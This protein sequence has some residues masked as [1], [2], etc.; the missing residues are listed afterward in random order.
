VQLVKA[1]VAADAA[2]LTT[3]DDSADVC[4]TE[5]AAERTGQQA[6]TATRGREFHWIGRQGRAAA[7]TQQWCLKFSLR[8]RS[9]RRSRAGRGAVED[10]WAVAP[11]ATEHGRE[12][13]RRTTT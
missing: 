1:A 10:D 6:A 4:A 7:R 5:R 11:T 2:V 8:R 3:A 12:P 13:S 9:Y